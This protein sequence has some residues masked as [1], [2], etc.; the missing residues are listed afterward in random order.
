MSA[1]RD[2]TF[3]QLFDVLELMNELAQEKYNLV[4]KNLYSCSKENLSKILT[5]TFID[6]IISN[7]YLRTFIEVTE[8]IPN[9]NKVTIVNN[10]RFI[11]Y[12]KQLPYL[13]EILI[14]KK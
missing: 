11:Y 4:I 1:Y 14:N 5:G 7:D 2:Y 13:K 3:T 10:S 12:L 9:Q 6:A 8:S